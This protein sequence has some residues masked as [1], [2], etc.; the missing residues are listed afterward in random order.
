FTVAEESCYPEF[1]KQLV[2]KTV[3][4]GSS[5][6]KSPVHDQVNNNRLWGA[7]YDGRAIMST[8]HERFL[9]GATVQDLQ[10]ILK[11]DHSAEEAVKLVST[12]AGT[13][14]GLVRQAKPAG[15]IV[16]EV[17]EGAKQ[18]IRTLAGKL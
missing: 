16:T 8:L 11:E 12:W 4:G 6:L 9:G 18:R 5:T 13:G 10:R 3:D 7:P 17:R 1:R 15:E 2:L 14:V